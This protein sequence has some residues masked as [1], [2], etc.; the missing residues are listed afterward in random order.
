VETRTP[1]DQ[2]DQATRT[3]AR[4]RVY[5]LL[6][7]ALRYPDQELL[8]ALCDGR[9]ASELRTWVQRCGTKGRALDA[10]L[11]VLPDPLPVDLAG[12]QAQH[13]RLFSS[14]SLCPQHESD[15]AASHAFQKADLM[16]DVAGFYAAFGMR[17]ATGHREL[18]DFIGTELEFMHLLC[19]KEAYAREQG[20]LAAAEVCRQAHQKFLAQHLGVWS[21]RC[22]ER[23][24]E[25]A[26]PACDA[27]RLGLAARFVA[28]EQAAHAPDARLPA[29]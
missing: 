20:D 10:T 22:G 2:P 19:T 13:S 14:G 16:A 9:W 8:A 23:L 17:V 29:P 27:S 5:A 6:S 26:A 21:G 24:V 28:E 3:L 12:L 11:G 4:G 25:S 18:P 15:Y 1:P 7:R